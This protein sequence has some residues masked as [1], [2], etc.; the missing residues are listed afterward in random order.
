MGAAVV[1]VLL[2]LVVLAVV[3]ALMVSAG[4]RRQ[5]E[6]AEIDRP[7]T[8]AL[9]YPV[10]EGQDPVPVVTALKDEGFDALAEG[11]DVVVKVPTDAARHRS[12]VREV[13]AAAPS[14]LEGDASPDQ[15]VRFTDE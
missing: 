4:R 6:V 11:H 9:R 13:I 10:P 8:A 7:E 5:R 1:P 14:N 15:D 2:V 12:R 3:A